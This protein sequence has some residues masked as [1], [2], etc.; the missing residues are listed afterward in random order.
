MTH[1]R[2]LSGHEKAVEIA[3]WLS[4]CASDPHTGPLDG[5]RGFVDP[6]MIPWCEKLNAIPGV[7]TIQS[8]SGHGSARTGYVESCGKIWL[9]LDP[10]MSW[11]FDRQAFRLASHDDLIEQV[12]R[13]YA[14]WGKEIASIAFAGNE[15]DSL[16][17]SMRLI[18]AF[19]RSL[20]PLTHQA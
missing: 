20:S 7:C 18:V 13:I 10:S 4:L 15:R 6:D 11:A 12:A 8:C 5:G 19:L 16:Y 9:L 3:R 1:S 14:P 17:R 2:Y